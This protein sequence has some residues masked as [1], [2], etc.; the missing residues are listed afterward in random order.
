M[1][2]KSSSSPGEEE[3][4]CVVKQTLYHQPLLRELARFCLGEASQSSP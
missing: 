4:L 3:D 1:C 2:L